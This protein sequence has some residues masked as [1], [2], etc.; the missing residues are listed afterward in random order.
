MRKM[1]VYPAGAEKK[2]NLPL[3]LEA[4]DSF[5]RRFLGLMGRKNIPSGY[6]LLIAPC[7][8]IHMCF[9]RFCI[10]AVYISKEYRVLKVVHN[11]HPW[12]GFSWCPKAWA[13]IEMKSGEAEAYGIRCGGVLKTEPDLPADSRRH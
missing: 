7:S 9:M 13:V 8:S 12:I 10:D 11:L 1:T 6:G 2:K 5:F 4:A 3:R